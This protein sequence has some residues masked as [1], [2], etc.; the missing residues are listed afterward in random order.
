MYV[1]GKARIK[2]SDNAF[3]NPTAK[4][5]RD[6]CVA[7]A[8][9]I[10]S[11]ETS[12]L[13]PT[14]ATGIRGIR[15]YLETRSKDVTLLDINK[16]AAAIA[17]KNLAFNKVKARLLNKSIQEFANTTDERFDIIDLDPFGSIAPNLYDILKI[18]KDGTYLT[19]SATDAAVLCG[20]HP[21]A[22]LKIYAAAAAIVNVTEVMQRFESP[23]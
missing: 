16:K 1:E 12:I 21:K 17:K 23:L 6:L 8:G 14:A 3:L 7:F 19:F 18:S 13:D 5:V 4:F 11:K 15:Y 10:A 2:Y 22:C 20:A 9:S